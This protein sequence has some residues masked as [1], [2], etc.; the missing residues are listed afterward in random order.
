MLTVLCTLLTGLFATE[1]FAAVFLT[2]RVDGRVTYKAKELGADIW[3]VHF[4]N[5]KG[6]SNDA[7]YLQL[8]TNDP[9]STGTFSNNVYH[10]TGTSESYSNIQANIGSVELS[11]LSDLVEIYVF[12][13]NTG[14]RNIIPNISATSSD[15]TIIQSSAELMFFD[16]SINHVDA[17]QKKTDSSK[18]INYLTLINNEIDAGRYSEFTDNSSIDYNDTFLAKIT[19]TIDTGVVDPNDTL[20]FD[21]TV[22][23]SFHAD[24]DYES[25]H[26][27]SVYKKLDQ[28][29]PEWTKYGENA[30]LNTSPIKFDTNAYNTLKNA[31]IN[32]D[33]NGNASCAKAD[34]YYDNQIIYKDIDLVNIDIATGELIGKLSDLNYNFE[35]YGREITLTSGTTLASGRTLTEDE[36]FV[37]DVY[38]YYPSFYARRWIVGNEQWI[39]ISD[40]EFVGAVKVDEF[41]TATFTSTIFDAEGYVATNTYG[42]IPRSYIYNHTPHTKYSANYLTDS[43]TTSKSGYNL[44]YKTNKAGDRSYT[45]LNSNGTKDESMSY[46]TTMLDYMTNLTKAWKDSS[47][48]GYKK[49]VSCQGENYTTFIYNLLYL[50]KY[51]TNDSQSAVGQGNSYAKQ[52]FSSAKTQPA[53]TTLKYDIANNEDRYISQRGGGTIGLYNS[54]SDA[55]LKGYVYANHLAYCDNFNHKDFTTA[56][57][58]AMPYSTGTGLWAN[59]FLTYN[60]GSKRYLCDGYVGS[61]G[62]TSVFCLGLSNP[63]GNMYTWVMGLSV[64]H[65]GTN[66]YAYLTD[67]DFDYEKNNWVRNNLSA[68]QGYADFKA[69]EDYMFEIG[70][71]KVSYSLPTPTEAQGDAN[72]SWWYYDHGIST[73]T[74]GNEFLSLIGMP[75]KASVSTKTGG[76]TGLCDAYNYSEGGGNYAFGFLK[77]GASANHLGSGLFYCGVNG[78]MSGSDYSI[79]FRSMIIVN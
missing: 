14:D 42:I 61:N 28:A 29:S 20:I 18:A 26:I 67:A 2:L 44:M 73:V 69:R 30:F 68:S 59:Q 4:V 56:Q 7:D 55:Y 60:N 22:Q 5:K 9:T 3:G 21:F 66:L 23:V 10:E 39:S 64:L 25:N 53:N 13:K 70:Y 43:S 58:Q 48:T 75:Y 15:T 46:Q 51:A 71:Q 52:L 38:T 74:E 41:Y 1:V 45:F 49:A 78:S 31:L 65:D 57:E 37:V 47:L 32:L 34:K 24:V 40:N 50:V 6:G 8:Y 79:A 77:G 19:F 72:G 27:L 54:A 35:W 33:S 62:Y 63:W 16:V 11:D 76:S 17:L 36:S 12:V